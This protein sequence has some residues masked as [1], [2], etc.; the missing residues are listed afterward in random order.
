MAN[1]SNQF[2][3]LSETQLITVILA[4]YV[5]EIFGQKK[6]SRIEETRYMQVEVLTVNKDTVRIR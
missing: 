2:K 4:A 6:K 3:F 1:V 5:L